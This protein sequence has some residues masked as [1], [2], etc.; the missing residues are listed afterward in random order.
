MSS[1]SLIASVGHSGSQ[2]P[3]EMHSSVILIAIAG[4]PPSQDI[5]NVVTTH[6]AKR[7]ERA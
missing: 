3:Q 7:F 2:A 4:F 6:F 5:M 1:A